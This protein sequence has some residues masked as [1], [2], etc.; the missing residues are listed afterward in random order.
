MFQIPLVNVGE[1]RLAVPLRQQTQVEFLHEAFVQF[2]HAI[3]DHLNW[4]RTHQVSEKGVCIETRQN[5]KHE[6]EC[7]EGKTL[8]DVCQNR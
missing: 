7:I 2:G 6:K 8:T 3:T 5:L 1:K 4:I